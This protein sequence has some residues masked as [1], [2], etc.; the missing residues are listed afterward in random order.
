M[1]DRVP[2]RYIFPNAI[3]ALSILLAAEAV[4]QAAAGYYDAAAWFLVWCVLLDRVDGVV[5]RLTKASSR[6]GEQFDSLADVIAFAFSPALLVFLMLTKDPRYIDWYSQPALRAVLMGSV[7]MYVLAGAIRLARFNLTAQSLGPGWFR[8]LPTTIA[9]A[10]VSTLLLAAWKGAWP[11][12]VVVAMPLVLCFCA[13]LMLSNLWLPKNLQ[14]IPNKVILSSRVIN[15][16][17]WFGVAVVYGLGAARMAPTV[18]LCLAV[19]Y[20]LVGFIL[21]ARFNPEK[22]AENESAP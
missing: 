19:G 3:T 18:L 5:A 2:L 1:L 9:G 6:F 22:Q 4:F 15:I 20:P 11:D 14:W 16:L 8:G 7:A 21:G 12:I 10:M 13:I 17:L